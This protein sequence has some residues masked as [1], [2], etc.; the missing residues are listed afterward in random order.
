MAGT[1][2][3]TGVE[4]L[5][6]IQPAPGHLFQVPADGL[7]GTI[8]FGVMGVVCIVW[9]A[10]ILVRQKNVVP[11][12]LCAGSA[13][14]VVNEPIVDVLGKIVYPHNFMWTIESFGR[15][16]PLILCPG[17]MAWCAMVP[18]YVARYMKR[19]AQKKTLYLIALFT[20]VSVVLTDT[21][22]TSNTHWVYYGEGL[23]HNFT[24]SLTMAAFPIVS[25]AML[26]LVYSRTGIAPKLAVFFTPLV[27]LSMSLAG[28]SF[29]LCFAMNTELPPVVDL[30]FRAMAPLLTAGIVWLIAE[31]V[32]ISR[33]TRTP[34]T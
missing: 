14:A 20:F 28:T 12:L 8:I 15:D 30:I 11:I 32:G 18:Y 34:A 4:I 10:V 23:L 7:Y 31:Q 5:K 25:G 9:A 26:F 33:S 1:T 21:I 13:L 3:L 27:A 16:I 29:T 19:G 22:A 2:G 6:N 24:G 17:Y